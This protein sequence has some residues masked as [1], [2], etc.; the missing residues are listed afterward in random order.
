MR[1]LGVLQ[2]EDYAISFLSNSACTSDKSCLLL[3]H[4]GA[5]QSAGA[6]SEAPLQLILP[7]LTD[8][9]VVQHA[10]AALYRGLICLSM[11]SVEAIL[12]LANA[13]GV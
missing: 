11:C 5:E 7:V 4:V 3:Q 10:V 2:V 9:A 1:R 6:Q 12:V 8:P 13:I